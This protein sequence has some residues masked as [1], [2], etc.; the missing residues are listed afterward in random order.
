MNTE[1]GETRDADTAPL[2][3]D[4]TRVYLAGWL[5]IREDAS[6]AFS[7]EQ[8]RQIQQVSGGRLDRIEHLAVQCLEDPA[9]RPGPGDERRLPLSW[10][11]A[12]GLMLVVIAS[13]VMLISPGPAGENVSEKLSLPAAENLKPAAKP[14]KPSE[15]SEPSAPADTS[16]AVP[17]ATPPTPP[18]PATTP[19][20]SPDGLRSAAWLREEDGSQY[21]LQLIGARDPATIDNYIQHA[22]IPKRRLTLLRARRGQ[23]DWYILLYGLYPDADA[24][25]AQR[26]KLPRY[27]RDLKP[28]PRRVNEVLADS[29]R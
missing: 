7:E 3:L 15:S 12:A 6:G 14:A 4:E 28:W 5:R 10:A 22:A 8:I 16:E 25:R 26:D 19:T 27:A 11:A 23:G 24:A 9:L 18:A 20:E 1:N 17:A 13:I 21:V 2:R 29:D